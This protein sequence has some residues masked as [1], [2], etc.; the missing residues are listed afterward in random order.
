[1]HVSGEL[2]YEATRAQ[3]EQALAATPEL[4]ARYALFPYLKTEM[5]EALAACDIALCRS[6]AA[7][8][9]ELSI[10]GRPS[11]LVP[12]P[13]GFTG[14]PQAVNA[15][16]FQKAGAAEMILNR[17]LTPGRAIELLAPLLG[18]ANRRRQMAVAARKLGH[19]AAAHDLAD[20]VASLADRTRRAP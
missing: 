8:L 20:L 12:L 9:A 6:G 19:P 16:M 10:I 15:A 7:T 2:T 17:E 3:A 18:D 13:P 11:V 5:P 14:S 1:L 4:R